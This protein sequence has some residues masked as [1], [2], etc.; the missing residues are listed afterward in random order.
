MISRCISVHVTRTRPIYGVRTAL[1][2]ISV[3]TV[4]HPTSTFDCCYYREMSKLDVFLDWAPSVLD[5]AKDALG[6]API[7]SLP[8]IAGALS[9]ICKRV[10]VSLSSFFTLL[11]DPHHNRSVFNRILARMTRHATISHERHKACMTP[12][13]DW[14]RK[15]RPERES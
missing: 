7:P 9:E 2:R 10:R 15:R 6:L 14:L 12:S 5:F 1:P 4:L 13:N 8:L 11:E 3:P